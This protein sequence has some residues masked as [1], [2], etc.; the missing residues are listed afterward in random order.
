M[1]ALAVLGLLAGCGRLGFGETTDGGT[2]DGARRDAAACVGSGNDDDGDGLV[3]ACDPC[4]HLAGTAAD[5]D[6]DGVGDACDPS[7][8]PDRFVLFDPFVGNTFDPRWQTGGTV[9]AGASVARFD[10]RGGLA[11]LAYEDVPGITEVGFRGT[12]LEVSTGVQQFSVQFGEITKPD[13]EYCEVYGNPG[14]EM[15]ITRLVGTDFSSIGSTPIT[16]LAPG[17]FSMRFRHTAT[18]FSCELVTGNQTYVVQ[19]SGDYAEP[20]S[21]TY[22]QFG[23]FLVTVDAFAEVEPGP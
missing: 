2:S 14:T 7:P 18:G 5:A 12:I 13:A 4:P 9:T 11:Y 22:L 15:K 19:G 16:P 21:F 17:P 10:A 1:R 3:D 8:G 6:G 20:R 23:E